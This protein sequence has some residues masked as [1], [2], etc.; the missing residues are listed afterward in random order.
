MRKRLQKK[1]IKKDYRI[2]IKLGKNIYFFEFKKRL[3][4]D[5]RDLG[6]PLRITSSG[7]EEINDKKLREIKSLKYNKDHYGLV[8]I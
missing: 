7:I 2:K 1:A 5:F 8:K 4:L 3:F 6:F